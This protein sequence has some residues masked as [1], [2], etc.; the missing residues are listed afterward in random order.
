MATV[1]ACATGPQRVEREPVAPLAWPDDSHATQLLVLNRVSFGPT[2]ASLKEIESL[3]TGAYLARQLRPA[4]EPRLPA[5]VR[6]MIDSMTISK[7]SVVDLASELEQR[8]RAFRSLPLE[9]AKI[10]R[11]AYQRDLTR[12]AREAQA[13][14]L[15]RALYSP[16]QLEEEMTWFWMNHFSVFQGKANVRA[17]VGDY[18]ERAI[19][20]HALGRFG[21]L[22]VAVAHHPAMLVYLDN[23]RNGVGRVNENYARE[24]ME[25]HTLGVKGGYNQ[26]DVQELARVLTGFSVHEGEFRFFPRRHD[27]GQKTLLGRPIRTS[28]ER[29]L[30]EALD[31]L[32]SHPSTAR[33]VSRKLAVHFVADDPPE[34]L[35]E[36]MARA[37]RASD[38]DIALT[39]KAMF[40]S[41]E[42]RAS[43][44]GKF[45]DP[46]HYMVS[47]VR[48][49]AEGEIVPREGV[50][51]MI[52]GLAAMGQ[53][54]YGRPTPDGYP[55]VRT[56]WT[57]PGQLATR[58][59]VARGVG[60][61]RVVRLS[62]E[63]PIPLSDTTR[64]TLSKA[65]DPRE[66][67]LLLLSSPEFMSR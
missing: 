27:F 18:E 33:F 59:E 63:L 20:P 30:G 16:D 40:E 51:R 37:F 17:L 55:L 24:L 58:F 26:A 66:W 4:A 52:N 2:P 47:A 60:Y 28:G 48:F 65:S 22:L 14:M 8:Q 36:R 10:E 45:K 7:R 12:L 23:A 50:E 21:D 13:R 42:F 34:A 31:L 11:Q 57:S 43:L 61:R 5:E 19:R 56:E 35:V 9:E 29:E 41:P 64:Q 49:A 38:G 1:C 53:P 6:A 15:L 39:L 46:L 54:L 67:N 62:D 25:L 32:A 3:G 44:G